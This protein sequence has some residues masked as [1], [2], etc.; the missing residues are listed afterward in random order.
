MEKPAKSRRDEKSLVAM[1][2]V[3]HLIGDTPATQPT[4]HAPWIMGER[5]LVE[6]DL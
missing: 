5:T 2:T 4:S 6:E 1:E 3:T